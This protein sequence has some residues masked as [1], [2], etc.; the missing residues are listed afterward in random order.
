MASVQQ[1][2]HTYMPCPVSM[3][4]SVIMLITGPLTTGREE[5]LFHEW[6]QITAIS[7]TDR[8][9]CG[10]LFFLSPL[11]QGLAELQHRL[12]IIYHYQTSHAFKDKLVFRSPIFCCMKIAEPQALTVAIVTAFSVEGPGFDSRCFPLLPQV[13]RWSVA[14]RITFDIWRQVKKWATKSRDKCFDVKKSG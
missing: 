7:M 9:P 8:L 2:L 6:W 5:L 3:T 14:L 11:G 1:P 10:C 4:F 13:G 12:L